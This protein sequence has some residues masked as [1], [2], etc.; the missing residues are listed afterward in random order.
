MVQKQKVS[1]CPGRGY[2]VL[3]IAVIVLLLIVSPVYAVSGEGGPTDVYI[4]VSEHLHIGE[5]GTGTPVPRV[6]VYLDGNPAGTT[7]DTGSITISNVMVKTHTLKLVKSGY[8][9]YTN[10]FTPGCNPGSC[11]STEEHDLNV[12]VPFPTNQGQVGT[13]PTAGAIPTVS[14]YANVQNGVTP[15][16][17]K[18]QA[19]SPSSGG[20][21]NGVT[22]QAYRTQAAGPSSNGSQNGV[23]PQAYMT[24]AGSVTPGGEA[25]RQTTSGALVF[26]PFIAVVLI[27][28]ITVMSRYRNSR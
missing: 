25:T 5:K 14:P 12:M 27:A 23:S 15:Q 6:M 19:V 10:S 28:G 11:P 16:A 9:D 2:A 18:T 21:Q 17:Y 24:Q 1:R 8:Q 4:A 3:I 22:P 13:T 7:D 20:S 26:T